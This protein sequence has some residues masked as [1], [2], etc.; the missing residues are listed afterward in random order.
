MTTQ[1]GVKLWPARWRSTM[2]VDPLDPR[3]LKGGNRRQLLADILRNTAGI[4]EAALT[5]GSGLA[6]LAGTGLGTLAGMGASKARGEPV[7][8]GAASEGMQAGKFTFAPRSE[9]GQEFGRGLATV[10]EPLERGMQAAGQKTADVTGSPAAGAAVYTALNVVDPEMLAPAAV[11]IAALRGASRLSREAKSAPV[12]SAGPGGRQRGAWSPADI[13]DVEGEFEFQSPSLAAFDKLK[14][15]EQGR[16]SG[17]QLGKALLREGA[18]KEELTWMGLDDIVNSDELVTAADVRKLAETNKPEFSYVTARAKAGDLELDED[19]INEAVSSAVYEDSDLAYPIAVYRGSGRNR[20]HLG[21]YDTQREARDA[22]QEMK[23]SDIESETQSYL[24]DIENYFDEDDLAT[25]SDADKESWAAESARESVNDNSEYDYDTNYDAEPTNED[26]LRTYWEEQIRANPQDYG[27]EGTGS[28]KPPSWGEYTLGKKGKHDPDVNYSVSAGKLVSEERYGKGNRDEPGFLKPY[29]HAAE[30]PELLSSDQMALFAPSEAATPQSKAF[31]IEAL[32]RTAARADPRSNL[33]SAEVD[34]S[35]FE[36]LGANQLFFTR[37][38]DRPAPPWGSVKQ[39]V[40]RVEGG[41]LYDPEGSPLESRQGDYYPMRML[42]E[43]QSDWLQSGRKTGWAE[44][45]TIE[46]LLAEEVDERSRV[47]AFQSQALAELPSILESDDIANF[48][49]PALA[50]N[51]DGTGSAA[52]ARLANALRRYEEMNVRNPAAHTM[53]SRT[54]A[55]HELFS[56]IYNQTEAGHPAETLA[57]QVRQGLDRLPTMTESPLKKTTPSA[58][59]RE[60]RQYTQLAV[61]DALRRAVQEGQQYFG[62]TPGDVHT[63]RWGT[64]TLQYAPS[65][66]NPRV[67]RYSAR[68]TSRSGKGTAMENLQESANELL[69][70]AAE[71]TQDLIDL[72]APDLDKQLEQLVESHL[73]YGMHEYP[74][75]KKQRQKRAA[76]LR[77]AMEAASKKAMAGQREAAHYSPRAFGNEA[78]YEPIGADLATI[79]RRSGV[80]MP[81][82]RDIED[83]GSKVRGIELDPEIARAAKRGFVLPY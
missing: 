68:D 1:P 6:D 38:T 27:I 81:Q 64:D 83:Y 16:V 17:K 2:A 65:P 63:K 12:S 44:P 75:P 5:L 70:E 24:D 4:P 55:A 79:L 7:A 41:G 32:R 25:M 15:Q 39:G 22:I 71:G 14:P 60:T 62:W 13:A 33:Y 54:T 80:K 56:T 78:A 30:Q 73:N 23:D 19:A 3:L 26:E 29:L 67:F 31:Q 61:A 49:Q 45:K 37:E 20:E 74:N 82:V 8:L 72:D 58:P 46:K 47:E 11:K 48:L 9:G 66:E 21:D 53:E 69:G 50:R 34:K 28:S 35:H 18:K 36:D 51:A 57:N 42:E 10:M 43:A 77:E 52:D 59:M 40:G 76:A